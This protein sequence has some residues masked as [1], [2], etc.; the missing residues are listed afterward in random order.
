MSGSRGGN[1]LLYQFSGSI[2]GSVSLPF[3]NGYPSS[4]QGFQ[5]IDATR[6]YRRTLPEID[7]AAV[8]GTEASRKGTPR[9]ATVGLEFV[10]DAADPVLQVFVAKVNQQTK[11]KVL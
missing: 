7:L 1:P 6:L 2:V 3:E 10:R 9:Y 5:R 11:A 4:L 8:L